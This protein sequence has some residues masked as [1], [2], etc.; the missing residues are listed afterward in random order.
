MSVPVATSG[1]DFL[2]GVVRY[3]INDL[4]YSDITV[5]DEDGGSSAGENQ[6]TFYTDNLPISSGFGTEMRIGRWFYTAYDTALECSGN[7]GYVFSQ[8]TGSFFLPSGATP[9]TSGDRVK[10]SYTWLSK[11]PNKFTD[12][13]IQLYLGDA[14]SVVNGNYYN[15]GHSFVAENGTFS[16]APA[17]GAG[18]L[19]TYVYAMY[20]TYLM[21]KQLESEGLSDRI[22]VRDI[23][24]TIDTTKGL[25]DLSKNSK[26]LLTQ[27]E[28]IMNTCRVDGQ[29]AAM[30]RIDTYSTKPISTAN[31]DSNNTDNSEI[32]G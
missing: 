6:E 19:A 32:W 13:E 12:K 5:V 8:T 17:P 26:E 16:I 23:N 27:F 14:V 29:A 25:S 22:F 7:R 9:A 2:V 31:Y 3:R 4:E 24:I 30:A 15:F 10:L 21:K 20:A 18:E 28:S 1:I 11:Q